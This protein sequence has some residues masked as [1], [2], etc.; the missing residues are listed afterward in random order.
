MD[1][2]CSI[3]RI[4][5][6][7]NQESNFTFCFVK[8]ALSLDSSNTSRI[9]ETC[10]NKL[11]TIIAADAHLHKLDL[12]ISKTKLPSFSPSKYET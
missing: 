2:A 6:I 8:F 9:V 4:F 11:T 7:V 12:H 1:A 5:K 3:R 10:E